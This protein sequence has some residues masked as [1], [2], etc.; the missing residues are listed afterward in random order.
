MRRT[1]RNQTQLEQ[2]LEYINSGH[3]LY[4][5]INVSSCKTRVAVRSE[6]L[7]LDVVP[8]TNRHSV[9]VFPED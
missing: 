6:T 2:S 7:T 1:K 3:T 8:K 5:K 4:W 9:V